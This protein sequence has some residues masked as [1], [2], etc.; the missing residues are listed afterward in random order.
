MKT[1]FFPPFS[2][3]YFIENRI[4]NSWNIN[5]HGLLGGALTFAYKTIQIILLF[6]KSL[7]YGLFLH[8]IVFSQIPDLRQ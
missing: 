8:I 6:H 2:Q 7:L 4:S 5:T 1:I 3:Y